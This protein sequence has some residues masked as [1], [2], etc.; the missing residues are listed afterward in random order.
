[1]G[2][3]EK[4]A[5]R[6]ESY[7]KETDFLCERQLKALDPELHKRYRSSVFA[8]DMLLANYKTVFPFFTNH[9][10]EHSAQVINY[11]NI[12]VGQQNIERLNADELY[13]LLMGACLHDIGMGICA[14]DFQAM[15]DAVPG[16]DAYMEAHPDDSIAEVTR[17]FHQEFSAQFIR[18][19]RDLFEIPS[20]EHLYCICQIARGHRKLDLLDETE[21]DPH[22]QLPGGAVVHLPYLAGL[23]K[24]ADELDVT[25]DRNLFFDYS[26][27]DD[28]GSP[29]QILC[30]KC[31][32]ALEQLGVEK[33]ALVLWFHAEEQEVRDEIADMDKK[34][35]KTFREF[36]AA[37][38]ERTDFSLV[39]TSVRFQE[40]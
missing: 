26:N 30:Y 12:L 19:Y 38:L 16:V 15:K 4:D 5:C 39:Q 25:A 23:V 31:H 34:V 7:S 20:E 9:T 14:S 22:Y 29:Y 27:L 8:M 36:S 11:C 18:K 17:S 24:M 13:I 32:K 35:Q 40:R 21:F 37:V 10:F 1:M 2:Q 28:C 33:D 3:T 6:P